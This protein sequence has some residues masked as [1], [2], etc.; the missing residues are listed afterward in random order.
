MPALTLDLFAASTDA[1]ASRYRILAGLRT[2]RGAF[3]HSE[4][5]P[6]LADLIAL[7]SDLAA[8]IDGVEAHRASA[9]GRVIGVDWDRGTLVTDGESAPPILAHELA[10]WALPEIDALIAEG[11]TL[12]EFVDAHA[13][14]SVVGL[15]PAYRSEG[16][17]VVH[18]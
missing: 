15:V 18:D 4:I 6:H 14:L 8:F 11:S 3:A 10:M 13:Q 7:R 1:E 2:V 5:Y 17:L 9:P 16:V 12:Y